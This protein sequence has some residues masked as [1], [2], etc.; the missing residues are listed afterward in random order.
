MNTNPT[1]S[2]SDTAILDE[3]TSSPARDPPATV[4][5]SPPRATAE[6]PVTEKEPASQSTPVASPAHSAAQ[7]RPAQGAQSPGQGSGT[8]RAEVEVTR[9]STGGGENIMTRMSPP[10]TNSSL[11]AQ[12]TYPISSSR[13]AALESLSLTE[14]HNEY[15]AQLGQHVKLES[16]MVK[17]MQKRHEVYTQLTQDFCLF[18]LVLCSPQAK[19][20]LLANELGAENNSNSLNFEI[21]DFANTAPSINRV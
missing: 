10:R 16:H 3:T 17:L 19:S 20:F 9:T 1:T 12:N 8:K 18:N 11:P 14:L 2:C 13:L 15:F 5:P 7:P 4:A 6:G 21:V